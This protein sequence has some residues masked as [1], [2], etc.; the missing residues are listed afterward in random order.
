MDTL[1]AQIQKMEGQPVAEH[2]EWSR[3]YDHVQ[4]KLYH[5]EWIRLGLFNVYDGYQIGEDELVDD[6]TEI[7][8]W[9]KRQN[10]EGSDVLLG[11]IE[12]VMRAFFAR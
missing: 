7:P 3:S 5:L 10:A 1:A 12:W 11:Y 2:Q 4:A 6:G 9:W 8:K